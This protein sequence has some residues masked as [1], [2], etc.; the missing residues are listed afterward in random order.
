[1]YAL[2]QAQ[3]GRLT[4]ARW[5]NEG[6]GFARADFHVEAI[7]RTLLIAVAKA[8][9]LEANM[10]ANRRTARRV[11]EIGHFLLRIEN[12]KDRRERDTR[13]PQRRIELDD[14]LHRSE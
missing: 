14:L 13:L 8:H 11:R 10:P 5:A 9:A 12:L 2:Q 4:A 3:Y 7:E 6:H 1:M